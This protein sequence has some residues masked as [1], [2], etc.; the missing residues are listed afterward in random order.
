MLE[1][2]FHFRL[3]TYPNMELTID[4]TTEE[5]YVGLKFKYTYLK[6]QITELMMLGNNKK[7]NRLNLF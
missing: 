6:C 4:K 1:R 7:N 3:F 2:S 5:L